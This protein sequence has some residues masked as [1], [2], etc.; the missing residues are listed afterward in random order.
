MAEDA[1]PVYATFITGRVESSFFAVYRKKSV[2]SNVL[3]IQ[4][5]IKNIQNI[6]YLKMLVKF[7][8]SVG[9]LDFSRI[10]IFSASNKYLWI[11]L[12]RVF[13]TITLTEKYWFIFWVKNNYENLYAAHIEMCPFLSRQ[14]YI[15]CTYISEYKM[16]SFYFSNCCVLEKFS[17]LFK[18]TISLIVNHG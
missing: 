10:E 17:F 3:K 11:F 2:V 1:L 8:I 9:L 16:G 7:R 5:G 18:G 4:L 6:L 13:S 15:Y 12:F 14:I